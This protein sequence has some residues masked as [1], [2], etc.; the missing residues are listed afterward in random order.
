VDVDLKRGDTGLCFGLSK[1]FSIILLWNP[2]S[3]YN[4]REAQIIQQYF[5]LLF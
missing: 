3:N 2:Y 1:S 4:E 5:L